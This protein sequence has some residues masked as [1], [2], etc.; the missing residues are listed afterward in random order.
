MLYENDQLYVCLAQY[1]LT[2]GHTVVVWKKCIPDIHLLKPS[3][4]EP[5][6]NMVE[7]TRSALLKTLNLSKVYLIYMDEAKHVHWHL[8]PRYNEK[9]Y[10]VLEHTPSQLKITV[11]ISTLVKKLRERLR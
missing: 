4:Y 11:Q 7:K 2:E 1:P 9:E 10:N 8:V 5:L 3:E 6:M